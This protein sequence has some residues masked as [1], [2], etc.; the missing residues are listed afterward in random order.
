MGRRH[1]LILLLA[2]VLATGRAAEAAPEPIEVAPGLYVRPGLPEDATR[3]NDDAIAN[4]GFVIGRNAVAVIDPGG[5]RGDGEDLR[6][7]IRAVTPLPIR[8][9]IMTHGHPDHVFGGIAFAADHPVF[10]GHARLPG[11]LQERGAF[12]RQRL[13]DILGADRAGDYAIP[14]RLV[15]GRDS[16]DLG[17]RVLDLAAHGAAHTDC[18]LTILDRRTGILWAGDLLFVGRI[19]SLDGSLTG[20]QAEL[21]RMRRWPATRAVPGHGPPIVPWPDGAED[22]IRYLGILTADT[23]RLIAEGG[24]IEAA[25]ERI[26]ES[27]RGKWQLFDDYNGRNAT[28]AFKQLEWE[29]GR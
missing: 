1:R 29:D 23:R 2:L 12:Y 16:I 19:P 11:V 22:E 20:W 14:T 4:I 6:R 8:W 18:D 17:D 25:P 21:D 7:A 24:D 15:A 9:V 27:E 26:A 3:A 28:V 10:V 5:S 13:S